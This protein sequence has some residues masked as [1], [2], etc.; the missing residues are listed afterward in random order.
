MR[1]R[2]A[3]V[4]AFALVAG[5][6]CSFSSAQ[7]V[8]GPP[9]LLQAELDQIITSQLEEMLFGRLPREHQSAI[10]AASPSEFCE[11]L[12]DDATVSD[13][14]YEHVKGYISR[15]GFDRMRPEHRLALATLI[16]SRIDGIAVPALCFEPGS[17]DDETAYAFSLVLFG[18]NARYQ[19]TTRW[20]STALSGGGLTQGTPTIL[21]YSFVPD[22]TFC[23][24]IT[25]WSG[26]S[27]L[28]AWL[29]S[30][31]GSQATWKPLFDQVFARWASLTGLSYVYEPNDDG[32]T[33]N[34]NPGVAGV[35][36]DVR[37]AAMTLDGN[38][39]VLAYNNFPQD[40]DMVLDAYD[41][42]YNI[43]SSNS[44]RLRNVVA[45]EHGHG[46]GMLHVCPANATKLMEPYVST[47]YDGPQTDD[48][49]NGNRHYGDYLEHNDTAATASALGDPGFG[50]SRTNV[51]I[52]DNS[53]VD[54]YSFTVAEP[55]QVVAS[56]TPRGGEYLQ[57]T[58]TSACDTGTLTNYNIVHNLAIDLIGTNGT[59]VL[60]TVNDYGVGV[61]ETLN[62]VV[63]DPG[64]YYLRVRGDAT[65]SCQ[66]YDLLV[67]TLPATPIVLN[68]ITPAPSVIA[69]GS[70]ASF[71]VEIIGVTQSIAAA[72][73][74]YR[75][76]GGA[77]QTI[78]L[79]GLGGNAYRATLPAPDCGDVPEFYIE[80][81]GSGGYVATLPSGGASDPYG[82]T[83]GVETVVMYDNAETNIGWTVTGTATDGQ[84]SRGVPAGDGTRGDPLVDGDGSGAAWLTDN[85]LGNS[86]VDN[87]TT[88]LTSPVLDASHPASVLS[89]WTW[90][91]NTAGAAPN[92]DV[93]TVEVSGNNGSTWTTVEVIGPTGPRASG[94]W[95][96]T[97]VS[98][99]NY[100]TPSNQFRIRFTAA[101]T[102]SGSVVEAGVDGV[103]ITAFSC[104]Q[105]QCLADFNSD[106]V[107]NFFDVQAFLAAFN[108][109]NPAADMNGDSNFDFFDVQAF[110]SAFAAGC[111]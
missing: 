54:Y 62:A 24:N 46:L 43:T 3:V 51:S 14:R 35:R 60:A 91:S 103:S 63:I 52:D 2:N 94:G 102:G 25:G 92:E 82:A 97:S 61:A 108:A 98:V 84:W 53:D 38:S 73:L 101:D 87:G 22:G 77:Y 71:D 33:L 86:D 70:I 7:L 109:H 6:T 47:S 21:T 58:Q 17:V 44:L 41:S 20:T 29:N 110:L 1:N 88:I 55:K 11:R 45:H 9:G 80:A 69:P 99:S 39:G 81:T 67:S 105:E 96:W 40:G 100:V 85:V 56:V 10:L 19:Q 48:I 42:F 8:D 50:V 74:R 57:G 83:V 37:I 15:D 66:L 104:E 106:G 107:L 75:D 79:S 68:T 78:A 90:F 30:R 36:G 49:L 76:N 32:V 72:N 64:T 28:F 111:P 34:Q 95:Y 12:P 27:T 16:R 5:G 31:Y 23:P 4:L 13:V 93:M 26:N 18:D 89:Y 65:N 59:T